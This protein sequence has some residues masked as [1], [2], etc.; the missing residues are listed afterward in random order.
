[1][2]TAQTNNSTSPV[3]ASGTTTGAMPS[4][5]GSTRPAAARNSTAPMALRAPGLKSSTQ[6]VAAPPAAASRSLGTNILALPIRQTVAIRPATIQ[7][8][9]F[10]LGSLNGGGG[11][12]SPALPGTRQHPAPVTSP[13]R[14][15]TSPPVRAPGAVEHAGR[16]ASCHRTPGC[17]VPG[18]AATDE[19]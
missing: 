2:V 7:S 5:A 4:T 9:R 1:M 12:L 3:A 19:P 11:L 10:I 17:L 14:P 15:V 8:A 6:R 16:S 18:V 13:P